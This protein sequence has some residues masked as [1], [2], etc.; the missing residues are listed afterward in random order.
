MKYL[1]SA[2]VL[3]L[4]ASTA[5]GNC[6]P[7]TVADPQE[8]ANAYPQQFELVEFLDAAGC[9]LTFS[10]NPKIGELNERTH[11]RQ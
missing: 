9:Q 5:Y 7:A 2:S 8:L 4:T 6:P 1:V 3:A 10:G 11:H